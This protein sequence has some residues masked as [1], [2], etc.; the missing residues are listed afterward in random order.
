MTYL[1]FVRRKMGLTQAELGEL[2]GVSRSLVAQYEN[3]PP[4]PD[5]IKVKIK[6]ILETVLKAPV[7]TLFSDV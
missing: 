2:L 3:H 1:E 5:N 6:N 4:D 7:T